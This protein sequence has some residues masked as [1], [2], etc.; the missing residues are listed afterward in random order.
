M[1]ECQTF[2]G[3][4]HDY[5]SERDAGNTAAEIAQQPRVWRELANL[6]LDREDEMRAFLDRVGDLD[7]RRIIFTGAGSSAFIGDALAPLLAK[8]PGLATESVPTTEIV[9]APH[10]FLFADVPTLLVSFARSGNSPE[11]VGAVEYA[12]AIVKDLYEVAI[13]CDGSAKLADITRQSPDSLLLV[14]PDDANDKGFAMTSSVSSMML[15]G[16]ALFNLADLD[17]LVADIALLSQNLEAA[18][19]DLV[20]LAKRLAKRD[21]DRIAF[22]GSGFLKH[23]GHEAALKTMELTNGIVNGSFES[24]TGF[25]HGPKSMIKDKTITVHFISPD[26]FSAHY[27]SDLLREVDSQKKDNVVVALGDEKA[28][29]LVGD[30]TLRLPAG[31][32]AVGGDISTGLIMLTFAQILALLKSIDLG[33]T[34]DNPSPGGEV[35]RVVEGVTVYEYAAD[36]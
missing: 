13:T 26:P 29:D 33:I 35:N 4:S 16:F 11:S 6:L 2:F 34:T 15:A 20:D 9:S 27:D 8:M 1:D 18:R 23:I 17:R 3:E 25:R 7:K 22:L 10:S 12:R 36:Q 32:S 5:F 31:Y 24:S 21:Y 14:M 28:A 19:G 30:E